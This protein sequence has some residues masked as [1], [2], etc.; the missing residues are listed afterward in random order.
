MHGEVVL[1]ENFFNAQG[2]KFSEVYFKLNLN[3]IKKSI[4]N[5]RSTKPLMIINEQKSNSSSSSSTDNNE[6]S[7]LNNDALLFKVRKIHFKKALPINKD[8][9][10]DILRYSWL[11]K[12]NKTAF[13]SQNGLRIQIKIHEISN[14]MTNRDEEVFG[15]K[16]TVSINGQ[17]PKFLGVQEPTFEEYLLQTKLQNLTYLEFCPCNTFKV[18]RFYVNNKEKDDQNLAIRINNIISNAWKESNTITSL[19]NNTVESRSFKTINRIIGKS[20]LENNF[21]DSNLN[22]V[23]RLAITW[24]VD[25]SDPNEIYFNRPKFEKVLSH[26]KK[27]NLKIFDETPYV[28]QSIKITSFNNSL[29]DLLKKSL[30]LA[31]H[32]ANPNIEENMFDIILENDD[33]NIFTSNNESSSFKVFKRNI[34]TNIQTSNKDE[35]KEYIFINFEK[36]N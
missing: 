24:L 35:T 6:N 9:V 17:D 8:Q 20:K 27:S 1:L 12:L 21:Y 22:S 33:D 14:Y 26:V 32:T 11:S 7:I 3:K 25:G 36:H 10:A 31:W 15:F 2:K 13:D 19:N 29:I 30:Q 18:D 28:K 4:L 23:S 5:K 16:Y 34:E